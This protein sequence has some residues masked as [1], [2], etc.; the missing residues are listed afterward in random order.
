MRNRRILMTGAAGGVGRTIR[1]LWT[2]RF[3]LLRLSDIA[4]LGEA[5]PGEELVTCD[6][7]DA[8]GVEAMCRGVDS[9][10]HFGGQATE[11]DWARINAANITG[12][13][14]LYEGARKGGVER[15]IFASSNHAVGMYRRDRIIDSAAP[16]RP[17]SRY[18][19]SKAFGEDMGQYYALKHG[20]RSMAIRIGSCFEKPVNA[21]MLSTWMSY[22]DMA[23]LLDVGLT[24]DFAH[25]IVYGI[26]R[27]TR[28]FYD[29][30]RAYELGYDPQDNAENWA[31]EVEHIVQTDPLDQAL[32]GGQFV[33]PEF[34]GRKDWVLG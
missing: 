14:N 3:G 10:I 7:A 16:P 5:G 2:G 30:A 18:G 12:L 15:V 13:I 34:T 19:L 26:S 17:D 8:A 24:A 4:T 29:N 21:R 11:A 27:N 28:A 23:R 1:R 9:I 31:P 33:S 25:E 20:I 22:G 32:Q 6:L